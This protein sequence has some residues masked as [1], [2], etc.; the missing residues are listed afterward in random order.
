[1]CWKTVGETF[2]ATFD[3][4][5][6]DTSSGVPDTTCLAAGVSGT[7]EPGGMF[8]AYEVLDT[9]VTAG[10]SYRYF[11]KGHFDIERD[12]VKT[13][14]EVTST[15]LEAQSMYPIQAGQLASQASPN[16]FRDRT[17]VSV[18]IPETRESEGSSGFDAS[19]LARTPV[20]V[21]VF[22]VGGRLVKRVYEG[23]LYGSVKTFE[24]DGTNEANEPV[25]SGV[26]FI[27]TVAGPGTDVKK[28]V[29]VR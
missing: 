15:A 13:H 1:V 12:G 27:R 26:Y 19:Q 18:R 7:Q 3:L 11:V 2:D 23:E 14:Y 5:R 4:H 25:G 6:I 8:C 29:V 22:D 20:S 24:W 17:R 21:A 28:A 9:K 10:R 16:P